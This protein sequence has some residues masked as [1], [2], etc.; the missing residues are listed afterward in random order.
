MLGIIINILHVSYFVVYVMGVLIVVNRF[1]LS[2]T[3][4]ILDY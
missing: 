2:K 4:T 3:R 1:L